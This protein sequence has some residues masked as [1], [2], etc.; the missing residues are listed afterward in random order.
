MCVLSNV[1]RF[2]IPLTVVHQAPLSVEFFQQE[3]WSALSFPTPGH[4]PDPGIEPTSPVSPALAG[5]FFT[6][7]ATWD[8]L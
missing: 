5:G 8:A 3:F 7:S 1:Q 4:P 2:M 6:T